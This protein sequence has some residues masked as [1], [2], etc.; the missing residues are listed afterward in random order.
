MDWIQRNPLVAALCL[1]G[2][3]LLIVIAGEAVYGPSL[4]SLLQSSPHRKGVAADAK[5][6]PPLVVA[7]AEQAYP[8]TTA[9]S[10]FIPTRRPA[11]EAPADE[12]GNKAKG[13]YVLVGVIVVGDNRTAMLKE[14][15]TGR[16][17][18]VERG[19]DVNGIK[20]AEIEPEV[21]TLAM[22]N[23][24]E[25]LP[26]TVQKGAAAAPGH[27]GAAPVPA[28]PQGPFAGTAAA[29]EAEAAEKQAAVPGQP[30][31]PPGANSPPG[32]QPNNPAARAKEAAKPNAPAPLS[33]E[34]LLARRRARRAQ[35]TPSQ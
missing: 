19:K 7:G 31:A 9:R 12:K 25:V 23:D 24:K 11:P 1:F 16:V 28:A 15:S 27:P 22:G 35:D 30:F 14:K 26:L 13:Q 33:T 20:V 2:A 10:L 21:V 32:A 18:H 5:L 17:F 3:V 6:L 8:E 29:Q 34:E 4:A